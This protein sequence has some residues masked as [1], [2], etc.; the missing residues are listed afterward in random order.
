MLQNEKTSIFV[1]KQQ[2]MAA[3]QAKVSQEKFC[4]LKAAPDKIIYPA[5][6]H[7]AQQQVV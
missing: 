5:V 7:V 3:F 6:Q 4:L 2:Q 1:A